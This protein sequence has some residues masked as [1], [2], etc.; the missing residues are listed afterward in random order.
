[1]ALQVTV[2]PDRVIE[3][4]GVRSTRAS[5]ADDEIVE[6]QGLRLTTGVRTLKDLAATWSL[7]DLVVMADAALCVGD[8]TPEELTLAAQGRG[9]RGVR[10]LRRSSTDRRPE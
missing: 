8:C 9:G 10:T 3:R 5:L 2:R 1:M 4:R 6:Y 7:V